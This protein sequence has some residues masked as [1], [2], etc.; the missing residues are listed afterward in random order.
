M[1]SIGNLIV[2]GLIGLMVPLAIAPRATAEE[3]TGKWHALFETPAGVQT[4]HFDFQNKDGKLTATAVVETGGQEREVE[5]EGVELADGILTFVEKRQFGDRQMVIEYTAKLGEKELELTRKLGD[6]GSQEVAATRELPRSEPVSTEPVVEVPIDRIIKDAFHDAF[7]IGTAGDFPARYSE[8]ELTLAA[9]H[10][11]A[12]TPENCMK[13]ERVHP[14]ESAWRFEP[15]DALVDWAAGNNMSIHG[16]TLVWHAQT[17]DWFFSGGDRNVV[18]QRM[19]EHITTL[20]GRY[21]GKIQSWD[22]VN[23][24]INDGGNDETGKTE[25]LRDSKWLQTLGPDFLTLAFKF[26]HEADPDAILYYND[27]NIESGAKHASSLVLLKRLLA[28]G[29]PVHAVGIQGHW[30]TGSV[31]YDEIDQ[32]ITNYAAL[33]LKVSITELDVTI[34]GASGGQFGGGLGRRRGGNVQPPSVEDLNA[35]AEAYGKLF[36]IFR[37]HQDVIE[38]VTFWGLNDRRTWRFG[39]HP[40][41]FDA[42]NHAK[43]AYAKIIEQAPSQ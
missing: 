27:Y 8:E 12:V 42:N 41:I 39:Q 2:I 32:A 35:Q 20:V 37:K 17:R 36:A 5:F 6:F 13:P 21:K 25:N 7:R 4:Y 38:R 34:R 40:L 31:P 33:G 3:L 26:A 15:C 14:E 16:H 9:Q 30:R 22:V 29:A 23:E 24:A 28:E 11:S 10:F 1:K 19:Q 18:T 43:P